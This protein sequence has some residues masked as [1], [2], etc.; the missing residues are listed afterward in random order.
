MPWHG[1]WAACCQVRHDGHYRRRRWHHGCRP[2]EGA[3]LAHSLGF[4]ITLPFEQRAN[5]TINGTLNVL[6][7]HFFFTRKLFFTKEA[8]A[9]VM[10]PGGFGTLDEVLE[11]V[12]LM[13][14]GKTPLV[15][16][17]LL[18]AEVLQ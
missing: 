8:D 11:V 9:L 12:T 13:Q 15:P 7:F 18:D 6:A 14:T 5:L 10:C 2:A 4:N 16:V 3:G 17:V 1:K